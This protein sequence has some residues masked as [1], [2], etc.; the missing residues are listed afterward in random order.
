MTFEHAIIATGSHPTKIP[1]LSFDSDRL[2][3]STDAL[4]LPDIPKTMLVVGGGY[5]GLEL[6]SVY[7]ALGT[8]VTVVERTDG[9]LPG[10]DRDLV[11]YLARRLE[12]TRDT[13]L[14][15]TRVV[16]ME[17]TRPEHHGRNCTADRSQRTQESHTQGLRSGLQPIKLLKQGPGRHDP[18]TLHVG[19][20]D[21]GHDTIVKTSSSV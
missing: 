2:M 8:K 10:A 6:G 1:G 13:I 17:D 16:G 3:D 9:L 19:V 5:I 12:T 20:Q 18:D 7:A 14:L 11:T 21:D 15:K 4:D